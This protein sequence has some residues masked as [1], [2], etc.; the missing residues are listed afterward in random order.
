MGIFS[1]KDVGVVKM[2]YCKNCGHEIRRH[3]GVWKHRMTG[4]YSGRVVYRIHCANQN[5]DLS[6]CHCEKPEPEEKK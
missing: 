1:S 3:E 4:S 6:I 2:Q 5:K